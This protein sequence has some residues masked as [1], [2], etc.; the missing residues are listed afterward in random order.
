MNNV[1]FISVLFCWAVV[2]V[3]VI[4]AVDPFLHP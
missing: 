3:V 1:V 4:V 2:V